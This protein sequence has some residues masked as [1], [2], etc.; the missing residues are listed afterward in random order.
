MS[1][2]TDTRVEVTDEPNYRNVA[3]E[4]TDGQVEFVDM[5]DEPTVEIN[6][7]PVSVVEAAGIL[8]DVADDIGTE[9]VR[10]A[11]GI[12]ADIDEESM[13]DFFENESTQTI[14]ASG[15]GIVV[16]DE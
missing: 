4:T 2:L 6:F 16:V 13:R 7:E 14:R 5:G 9:A 10:V 3:F 12:L 15:D 8:G 11:C 1:K